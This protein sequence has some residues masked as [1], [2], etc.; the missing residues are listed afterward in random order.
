MEGWNDGIKR[1]DSYLSPPLFQHSIIP[2][3]WHID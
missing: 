3:N 1:L 2:I